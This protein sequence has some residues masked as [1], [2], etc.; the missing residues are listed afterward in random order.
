MPDRD[1]L[2][3]GRGRLVANA[4]KVRAFLENVAKRQIPVAY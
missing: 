3:L 1:M 2:N 4:C